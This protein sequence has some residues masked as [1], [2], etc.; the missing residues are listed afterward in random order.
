MPALALAL[1]LAPQIPLHTPTHIP[2]HLLVA[3]SQMRMEPSAEQLYTFSGFAFRVR[4]G[5]SIQ[6]A[7]WGVQPA[8]TDAGL[9]LQW[10]KGG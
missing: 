2:R 8:F 6:T 10:R 5:V 1:V 3:R 9:I 4:F 7:Q